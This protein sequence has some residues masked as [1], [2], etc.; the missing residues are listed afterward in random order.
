MAAHGVT[1]VGGS[2]TCG[3]ASGATRV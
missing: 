3:Q 2:M 1:F